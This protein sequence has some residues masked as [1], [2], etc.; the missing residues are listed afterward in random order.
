MLKIVKK[1]RPSL[2]KE[3]RLLDK[4]LREIKVRIEEKKK[5]DY[6]N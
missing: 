3:N 2:F 1:N 5:R 4:K 6:I